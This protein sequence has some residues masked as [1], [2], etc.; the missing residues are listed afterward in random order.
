MKYRPLQ[1][2]LQALPTSND[3]VTLSFADIER[4]IGAKLPRS[5]S[6]HAPWWANQDYGSQAASWLGAG[7]TA[8]NV[9]LGQ[10]RV[11]FRRSE[12]PR[13]RTQSRKTGKETRSRNAREPIKAETLLAAGFEKF[14]HWEVTGESIALAGKIPSDPGVY[15]HVVDGKVYYIGSATMGLKRRLYFYGKPGK[16]Q[17]TSIRINGLI[18]EELRKGK[19]VE[20][21]AAIPKPSTWNG[22][23]VDNVTGL[24]NAL[25]KAHC[26]PWNKRGVAG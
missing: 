23:P 15:A 16:T 22:L 4:I 2:Y 20:L 12:A 21:I 10:K 24:E 11:T 5:A 18:L 8:E 3:S 19:A 9:K 26:P 1:N 25:I 14:G 7:F 6:D 13:R 17:T